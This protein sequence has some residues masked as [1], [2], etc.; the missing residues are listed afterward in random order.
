MSLGFISNNFHCRTSGRQRGLPPL[1]ACVSFW[2]RCTKQRR[3][4]RRTQGSRCKC[5]VARSV[6]S[7]HLVN[8]NRQP[9]RLNPEMAEMTSRERLLTAIR[10]EEP[11]RVPVAPHVSTRMVDQMSQREWQQLRRRTDVTL[12]VGGLGD[13][14]IFSGAARQ[15]IRRVHRD[16]DLLTEIIQTPKGALTAQRRFTRDTSWVTEHLVK[17]PEDVTKLLS[18]PYSPPDPDVQTYHEWVKSIGDEGLVALGMPSPFRLVLGLF[19]SE[20]LYMQMAEDISLVEQVVATFAPRVQTYVQRC[21]AK[22]VRSF[23][24]GGS[25]HCGPGVVNPRVFHRLVTR[26]DREIVRVMHKHGAM[27]NYHTHGKLS[28]ILDQIAEIG[29]DIMSPIETG[30]RGDVTLAEVKKRV[31]DRICLKGNLDDMAFLMVEDEQAVREAAKHC[32]QAAAR[33]GGYILSGTDAGIYRPEWVQAFLVLSDVAR[34]N[35]R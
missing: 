32:I 30:L 1:P 18:I 20:N 17:A 31:G 35:A 21:C 9:V 3:S 12:S 22:G 34:A 5:S 14:E 2:G 26:H 6:A 16:G 10:H 7:R 15:E 11:D 33:G 8:P 4:S 24:M 19:G 25:E 28:A 27:V 29:V 13:I 23:W